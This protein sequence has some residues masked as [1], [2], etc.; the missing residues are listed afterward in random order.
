VIQ[1]SGKLTCFAPA[2]GSWLPQTDNEIRV[3]NATKP[4]KVISACR[5]GHVM[6]T[7]IH[8]SAMNTAALPSRKSSNQYIS[9][10]TNS[11]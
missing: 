5:K 3:R 8:C 4:G 7:A 10:D 2:S 1:V 6:T 11:Q 9:S